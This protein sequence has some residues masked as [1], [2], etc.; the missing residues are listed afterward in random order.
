MAHNAAFFYHDMQSKRKL[1]N[2]VASGLLSFADG[3]KKLLQLAGVMHRHENVGAS[4]KFA[5]HKN[6]SPG[7]IILV[8]GQRSQITQMSAHL[9][10]CWPVAELLNPFSDGGIS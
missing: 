2:R 8:T 9:W 4:H 3:V 7:Q 6:L 1:G 10:D 5:F